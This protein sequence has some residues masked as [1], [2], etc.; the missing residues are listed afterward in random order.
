MATTECIML[1]GTRGTVERVVH[2][3]KEHE[4]NRYEQAGYEGYEDLTAWA[5][6]GGKKVPLQSGY[7]GGAFV[8]RIDEN[9]PE[10]VDVC[11]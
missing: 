8:W 7:W 1:P 3:V 10:D 9:Y 2:G 6:L 5:W 4:P 11:E